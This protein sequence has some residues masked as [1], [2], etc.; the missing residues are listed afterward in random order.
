VESLAYEIQV[1]AEPTK[2][3]LRGHHEIVYLRCGRGDHSGSSGT[4]VCSAKHRTVT[5]AEVRAELV[6]LEKAGYNPNDWINYPENLQAAQQRVDAERIA[7]A[8]APAVTKSAS[9]Q[10]SVAGS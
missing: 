10:S 7:Q 5:R 9:A 2:K 1:T 6:A 4:F 3:Q 8:H